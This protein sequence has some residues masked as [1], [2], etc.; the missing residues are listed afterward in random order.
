MYVIQFECGID[1]KGYLATQLNR[2]Q[3]VNFQTAITEIIM[4]LKFKHQHAADLQ[5]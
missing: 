2:D 3:G 5:K 4:E 1:T